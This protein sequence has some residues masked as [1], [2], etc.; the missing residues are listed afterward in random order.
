[1]KKITIA[2]PSK[3]PVN[4]LSPSLL[5]FKETIYPSCPFNVECYFP[6]YKSQSFEVWSIDP[7]A[8][9]FLW[10]SKATATT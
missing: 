9:K 4:I 1:M 2:V 5:K 3:E 7:V 10:G 8:K 6:V